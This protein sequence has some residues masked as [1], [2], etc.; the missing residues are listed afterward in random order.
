MEIGQVLL[1]HG[2]DVNAATMSG[3]TALHHAAFR[4]HRSFA[5]LLVSHR[6]QVDFQ[7]EPPSFRLYMGIPPAVLNRTP[8]HWA[9]SHGRV[10]LVRWLLE[11]GANPDLTDGSA[12]TPY[13][14]AARNIS[15]PPFVYSL[16][17]PRPGIGPA[18]FSPTDRLPNVSEADS[19][20]IQ[21]LLREHRRKAVEVK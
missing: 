11:Q 18:M 21:N 7:P 5:E 1:E 12:Q 6:A 14:L 13:D 17:A 3:A 16:A 10:E 4:G 15:G 8:L 9:V 2:T 20:A 19:A